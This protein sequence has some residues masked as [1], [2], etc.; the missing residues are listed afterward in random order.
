MVPIIVIDLVAYGSLSR[1]VKG[2][3]IVHIITNSDNI[4]SHISLG[5][6][7]SNISDRYIANKDTEHEKVTVNMNF[8]KK[9]RIYFSIRYR[10]TIK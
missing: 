5:N 8:E 2:V 10:V 6:F 7:K 4:I 9:F 3:T 1:S